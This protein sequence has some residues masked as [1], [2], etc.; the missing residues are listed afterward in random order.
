[1]RRAA[2]RARYD[3][4]AV[5][6][7]LDAGFVAHVGIADGDDPTVIPMVYARDGDRLLL[8][9]SVASRLMRHGAV[10][11]PVCV[12]VTHVDG[13]VLARSAFHHSV[14]YRSV[15]VRGVATKVTDADALAAGF[16]RLVDHAA[17]G[18]SEVVRAPDRA[19]T[20]QTML[21]EV[22]LD[23]ASVKVRTGP[24]IDDERDLDL[25]VWAGVVPLPVVPAEPVPA[26]GLPPGAGAPPAQVTHP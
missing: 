9:G 15:V 6:A 16:A 3:A 12:A 25:P 8:H 1:V 11:F 23:D 5:H 24:P 21:L 18:R 26:E 14:N 19:E 7:V 4:P 17:P 13:L 2:D 10:G 20:R 22:A